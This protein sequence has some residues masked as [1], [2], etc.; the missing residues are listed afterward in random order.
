MIIGVELYIA[1]EHLEKEK[2]N[3]ILYSPIVLAYSCLCFSK[4]CSGAQYRSLESVH[5]YV[6]Q[7]LVVGQGVSRL[8]IGRFYPNQLWLLRSR[9]G[10]STGPWNINQIWHTRPVVDPVVTFDACSSGLQDVSSLIASGEDICN[11]PTMESRSETHYDSDVEL[12]VYAHFIISD[13]FLILHR[14]LESL[15]DSFKV[16]I[17]DHGRYYSSRYRRCCSSR[18][19]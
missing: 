4:S 19:A 3:M 7:D 15:D 16:I 17:S 9:G 18:E 10:V 6:Y 5:P 13:P 2:H 8:L 1:A 14:S 11:P 12:D